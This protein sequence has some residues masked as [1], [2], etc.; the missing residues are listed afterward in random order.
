MC[1]DGN[2][3]AVCR[4]P[5]S[6]VDK[7]FGFYEDTFGLTKLIYGLL[8]CFPRDVCVYMFVNCCVDVSMY[9]AIYSYRL[10]IVGCRSSYLVIVMVTGCG[11]VC[12]VCSLCICLSYLF[13]NID[14]LAE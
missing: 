8:L 12:V 2:A 1:D 11:G 14:F 10:F 6:P 13:I 7:L 3:D 5:T 4:K 9:V